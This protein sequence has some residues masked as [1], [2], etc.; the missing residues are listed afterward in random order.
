MLEG[1]RNPLVLP[2]WSPGLR[3]LELGA[4]PVVE[5]FGSIGRHRETTPPAPAGPAVLSD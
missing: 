1:Q 5:L 2:D 4:P 3:W